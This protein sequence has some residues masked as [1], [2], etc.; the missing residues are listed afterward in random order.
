MKELV[1]I[2][3]IFQFL[4]Y[5]YKFLKISNIF[6]EDGLDD[7]SKLKFRISYYDNQPKDILYKDYDKYIENNF[8]LIAP[9]IIESVSDDGE[10]SDIWSLGCII[11][12]LKYQKF[13]F[14]SKEDIKNGNVDLPKNDFSD[15]TKIIQKSLI[16]EEIN[17]ITWKDFPKARFFNPD[18]KIEIKYIEDQNGKYDGYCKI[19]TTIKHGLGFFLYK[20]GNKYDG[21]W[22]S[23]NTHGKGILNFV[24]GHKFVGDFVMNKI[25]G[26]GIYYYSN[27]EKYEGNWKN[28]KFSGHGTMYYLD[29]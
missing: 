17:R 18:P 1:N 3:R 29:G 14:N 7:L 10:K 21:E 26:H 4:E 8:T 9:E 19:R 24:E 15:L 12:Y 11:Y 6:I 22:D 13:P 23:D 20:N 2:F 16:V 28:N 5:N 27:G 25:E